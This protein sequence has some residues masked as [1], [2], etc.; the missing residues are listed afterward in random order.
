MIVPVIR[1]VNSRWHC[2]HILQMLFKRQSSTS[3]RV[4]K[5]STHLDWFVFFIFHYHT[6]TDSLQFIYSIWYWKMIS[7]KPFRSTGPQTNYLQ[8]L[9]LSSNW[10][11]FSPDWKRK[12][13]YTRIVNIVQHHALDFNCLWRRE[14]C[15]SI[16]FIKKKRKEIAVFFAKAC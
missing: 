1:E 14:K 16:F 10:I 12:L 7:R 9:M 13:L 8:F 3:C 2:N 4:Y 15:K 11:H 6:D 5:T